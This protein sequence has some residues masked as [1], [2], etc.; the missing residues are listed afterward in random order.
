MINQQLLDFIKHQLQLGL[1]KEKI[2]NDLFNKWM[3]SPRYR[4]RF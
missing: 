2:S 3:D 4:R 1:T